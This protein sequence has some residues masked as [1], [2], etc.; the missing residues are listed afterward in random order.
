MRQALFITSRYF[1]KLYLKSSKE[2]DAL[3][4]AGIPLRIALSSCFLSQAAN[5]AHE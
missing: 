1:L 5:T 2:H 3:M 4:F